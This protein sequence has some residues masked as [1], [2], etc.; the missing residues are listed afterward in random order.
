[1][2]VAAELRQRDPDCRIVFVGTDRPLEMRMLEGTGYEH[3]SL[4]VESTAVLLRNPWRFLWGNWQAYRQS[5]KILEKHRPAGV[6]GLGGFASAPLLWVA[7]RRGIA[8]IVLEGNAIPGR[9]T[10]IVCRR[11]RA[12]CSAFPGLGAKLPPGTNV[13][14]TGNPVRPEIA[15]LFQDSADPSAGNRQTLLI[16]G[17]SLGAEGLNQAVA[18]VLERGFEDLAGWKIIHQTGPSQHDVL[19]RRYETAGFNFEV[20][21]FFDDM[22]SVYRQST[23][24]IARAGAGTLAELACAGIPAILMPYP[25]A[26]DNHQL[27]NARVYENAGAAVLVEHAADLAATTDHL[28][29]ALTAIAS[30]TSQLHNMRTAMRHFARPHAARQVVEMLLSIIV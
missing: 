5:L 22:P 21:P 24:A 28:A 1:L 2:A 4:P 26:A 17:G 15:E 11:A 19:A 10:R 8:S 27:A 23:L 13:V 3:L 29:R 30:N 20:Q 9:A 7:P 14:E 25:Q 6:I 16:L 12:V 18:T